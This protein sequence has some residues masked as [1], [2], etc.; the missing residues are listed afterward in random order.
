MTRRAFAEAAGI[1][2]VTLKAIETRGVK[3]RPATIAKIE[4]LMAEIRASEQSELLDDRATRAAE[5]AAAKLAADK[6]RRL[7]AMLDRA[8][9]AARRPMKKSAKQGGLF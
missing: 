8:M 7:D 6:Q 1:P 9:R 3:P 4:K 5:K 2:V